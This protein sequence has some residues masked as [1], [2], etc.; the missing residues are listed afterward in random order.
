MP[1]ALP[2]PV[3]S[4]RPLTAILLGLALLTGAPAAF[5]DPGIV[6]PASVPRLEGAR[7][8]SRASLT[9]LNYTAPGSVPVTMLNLRRLLAADGWVAYLHPIDNSSTTAYFKKGGQGLIVTVTMDKGKT[10]SSSIDY[11]PQ[12]IYADLPFPRD[13]TDIVYDEGRPYLGCQAPGTVEGVLATFRNELPAAGWTPLTPDAIRGRWPAAELADAPAGG[14]R[15]YF[16][17]ANGLP[18]MLTLRPQPEGRVAI[19]VRVAPFALPQ[20]LVLDS[21]SYGLPTPKNTKSSSRRNG[22]LRRELTAM[23]VA[24][25]GP[26]LAFYRRELV[27]RGWSESAEGAVTKPDEVR[28]TFNSPTEGKASLVL[29]QAYDFTSVSLVVQVP[30][31]LAAERARAKRAAQEAEIAGLMKQAEAS[32]REAAAASEARNAATAGQKLTAS[33]EQKAAIPLPETAT[34]VE[35]GEGSLRYSSASSVAQVAA[36][37]R[38]SLQAQGWKETPSVINRPN[39]QVLDFGKGGQRLS[40]TIMQMGPNVSVSGSGSGLRAAATAA[41]AAP[42]P[43]ADLDG[44]ESSGLPVPKPATLKAPSTMTIKG[45]T[46]PLRRE[47]EA[48]VSASLDSVLAFYRRELGKRAW[49]EN[50][51]AVL[52]PDSVRIAYAAPDGPAVLRLDRSGNETRINLAVKNVAEAKKTGTA[53]A[54]GQAKLVLGNMG[55]AAVSISLNGKT[56]NV[57]AG[58]GSPATPDGPTM[59]LK[60]GSYKYVIKAGARS[61]SGKLELGTDDT[62]GLLVAPDGADA[63]AL[64]IY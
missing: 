26:V 4:P 32:A 14:A 63:L 57:P 17:R 8:G 62:W 28:L 9:G 56:V 7:D 13:A 61:S 11:Y 1:R 21:D 35:A 5:A 53:P 59:E 47:L 58:A 38:A 24:E 51:G 40:L 10:D 25:I 2:N 34:G 19:D 22:E 31:Q 46:V 39:M 16:G 49:K 54:D 27:A 48:S 15:A 52:K 60:P 41:P 55:G 12:R 6:D 23:T 36:F 37:H 45:G 29:G 50:P 44:E 18:I 64:Q 33:S 3:R 43:V 42:A 30:P 20:D